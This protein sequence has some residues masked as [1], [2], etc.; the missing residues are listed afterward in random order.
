MNEICLN[1]EVVDLNV[2]VVAVS[3]R[4]GGGT[5][6]VD[7]NTRKYEPKTEPLYQRFMIN[8]FGLGIDA[9]IGAGFEKRR[10]NVRCCN[11]VVYAL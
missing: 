9:K 2:W 8:Y 11:K 1:S 10:T 4:E 3:Y 7:P 5:Y 6:Q